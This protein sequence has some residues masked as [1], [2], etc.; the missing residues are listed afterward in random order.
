MPKGKGLLA[1]I[2]E[3]EDAAESTDPEDYSE[4]KTA[5]AEELLDAIKASD[6]G[7]VADAVTALIRTCQLE[8]MSEE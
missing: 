5:A 6:P 7:G 1:L 3:P 8:G 2:S 4:R